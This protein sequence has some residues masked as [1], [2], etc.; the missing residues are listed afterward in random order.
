MASADSVVQQLLEQGKRDHHAW[1]NGQVNQTNYARR[2]DVTL[3]NPFG[4]YRGRG[5]E[6]GVSATRQS[7]IGYFESGSEASIELIQAITSDDLIVLVTI[8]RAQVKFAG[9]DEPHPWV[10]RV[11]EVYHRDGD[12]W[13]KVHRHA[14]PLIY[15]RSLDET[16][17]LLEPPQGDA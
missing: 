10:L 11:T 13:R 2:D 14:D 9:R 6:A 16:L 1:I 12:T 17:V 15:P 8:E 3:L 5:Y 4:G 7:A